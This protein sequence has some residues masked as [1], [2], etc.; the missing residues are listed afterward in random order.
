LTSTKPLYTQTLT[1][2]PLAPITSAELLQTVD[3]SP[4]GEIYVSSNNQL[5]FT[6][7][8]AEWTIVPHENI[9]HIDDLHFFSDG[10][11]LIESDNTLY[12]LSSD[13]QWYS[14]YQ[15]TRLTSGNEQIITILEDILYIWNNDGF[16][17]STDRG[18]T[19]STFYDIKTSLNPRQEEYQIRISDNYLYLIFRDR[20][21]ILDKSYQLFVDIVHDLDDYNFDLSSTI[22]YITSNDR[23]I[24]YRRY[25]HWSNLGNS[26]SWDRILLVP[27]ALNQDLYQDDITLPLSKTIDNVSLKNRDIMFFRDSLAYFSDVV[28]SND[29]DNIYLV[30]INTMD[31]TTRQINDD[32]NYHILDNGEKTIGYDDM[33]MMISIF[34]F[35]IISRILLSSKLCLN[36]IM[37]NA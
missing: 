8:N 4:T 25:D 3:L 11:F 7:D 10:E 16:F 26:F 2:E 33:V 14:I 18:E 32:A 34:I 21:T 12:R 24:N 5:Y 13:S 15:S 31:G 29:S 35:L 6:S 27:S 19:L 22:N 1:L 17:G 20:Y 30:E 37:L 23:I 36:Y 28:H 9:S